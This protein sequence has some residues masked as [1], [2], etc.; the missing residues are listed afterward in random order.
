MRIGRCFHCEDNGI[1]IVHPLS[2]TYL[3]QSF[4]FE[5]MARRKHSVT[6]DEL[7]GDGELRTVFFD[8]SEDDCIYFDPAWDAHFSMRLN[9]E[10]ERELEGENGA[11]S[12]AQM[13]K[14][15]EVAQAMAAFIDLGRKTMVTRME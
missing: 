8:T 13:H 14:V 2:H 9:E 1:K 12:R 15:K 10:A 6:N 4:D 3:G 11:S 5:E 7:V